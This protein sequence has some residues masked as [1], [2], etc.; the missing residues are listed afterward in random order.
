MNKI[1][2]LLV[3]VFSITTI[4][5]V[6][7]FVKA[8]IIDT[9]NCPT[10]SNIC[11]DINA[12]PGASNSELFGPNGPVTKITS[13]LAILMG[14]VAVIVMIYAG[15]SYI[16]SGGDSK[17]VGMAK[18]SIIYAA[19]GIVIALSAQAIVSFVLVNIK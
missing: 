16:T 9:T 11:N 14:I 4:V 3:A 15:Y 2:H 18:N 6:P 19:I 7:T 8:E 1:K 12:T 5:L 17:K 10:G 13:F